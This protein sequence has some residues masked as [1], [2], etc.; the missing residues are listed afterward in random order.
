MSGTNQSAPPIIRDLRT[1]SYYNEEIQQSKRS[2]SSLSEETGA[3]I[4]YDTASYN[5]R[6]KKIKSK[7]HKKRT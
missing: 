3:N 1:Y 6:L 7:S 5:Q 4:N 2:S